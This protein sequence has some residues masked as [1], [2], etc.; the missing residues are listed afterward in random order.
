[1]TFASFEIMPFGGKAVIC[2]SKV[3]VTIC[4]GFNVPT[5]IPVS[6]V[7]LGCGMPLIV[8][9]PGINVVPVGIE[10]VIMTLVAGILPVF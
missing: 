7:K 3:T 2:T 6:G 10:S 4:L 5:G 9:L 1:M 8:T